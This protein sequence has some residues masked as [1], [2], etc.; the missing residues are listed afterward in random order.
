MDG[1]QSMS[2]CAP[3][4]RLRSLME[5]S[6]CSALISFTP[7]IAAGTDAAP[8]IGTAI[9]SRMLSSIVRRFVALSRYAWRRE[10]AADAAK[11]QG[12]LPAACCGVIT[13]ITS[14]ASEA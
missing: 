11:P 14:V 12:S 4:R 2:I 13:K 7:D 9:D 10:W 3:I 5:T 6:G 1:R 8:R